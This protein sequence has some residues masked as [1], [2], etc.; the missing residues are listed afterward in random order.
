MSLVAAGMVHNRNIVKFSIYT[1]P[2]ILLFFIIFYYFFRFRSSF[3]LEGPL[4]LTLAAVFPLPF[5]VHFVSVL[6]L[7]VFVA[8]CMVKQNKYNNI[9]ENAFHQLF[10]EI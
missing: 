4:L 2:P 6:I 9:W 3:K 10:I 5:F 7:L 8:F 1:T